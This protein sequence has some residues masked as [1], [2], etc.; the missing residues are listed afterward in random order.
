MET[1]AR[2]WFEGARRLR[3][4]TKMGAW[5]MVHPS[6]VNGTELGVQEWQDALFLQYGLD[7][8]YLPHYCNG[9]STT[10]SICHALNYNWGV[11]VMARHNKLR[12]RVADLARKSFKP[13][14]VRNDPLIITGCAGKRPKEKTTR[15]KSMKS[16]AA[17]SP[18]E[19][20][21]QRGDL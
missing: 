6:M 13:N 4:A 16:I 8:P 20:T 5:L 7:P 9:C 11:F 14:H 21:G 19:A 18:L 10:F 12:D 1:L 15:S 17:T 2:G 3:Q